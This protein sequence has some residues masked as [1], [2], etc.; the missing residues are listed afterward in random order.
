MGIEI[1]GIFIGT[2]LNE[3]LEQY[4]NLYN[5]MQMSYKFITFVRIN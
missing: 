5:K 3:I 1:S 4:K 2:K